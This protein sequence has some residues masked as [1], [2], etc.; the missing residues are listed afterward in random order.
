MNTML[1]PL[2]VL[3][4]VLS[5]GAG[6]GEFE[7]GMMELEDASA[8]VAEGQVDDGR[9][10]LELVQM[11]HPDSLEATISLYTQGLI[12]G[13]YD[14]DPF[15]AVEL[16]QQAD[17]S[18]LDTRLPPELMN[19]VRIQIQYSLAMYMAEKGDCRTALEAFDAMKDLALD[20]ILEPA[21]FVTGHIAAGDCADKV[22]DSEAAL[23]WYH[24]AMSGMT[25]SLRDLYGIPVELKM[26]RVAADAEDLQAA[27]MSLDGAWRNQAYVKN[28]LSP[29]IKLE[30]SMLYGRLSDTDAQVAALHSAL[31][32]V[33]TLLA[34]QEGND[35]LFLFEAPFSIRAL[36]ELEMHYTAL[37][38]K[39]EASAAHQA[40]MDMIQEIDDLLNGK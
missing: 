25:A 3:P 40:R 7:M 9:Q 23:G 19:Q 35:Q 1:K 14:D 6:C 17:A 10:S 30:Q 24:D 36:E 39:E 4:F 2:V 16:L 11:N 5:L 29:L 27:L 18:L 13:E 12:A 38:M 33:D 31:H 37:E 8:A 32:R 15:T 20:R 21:T 34:A 28:E 22:D 26:A